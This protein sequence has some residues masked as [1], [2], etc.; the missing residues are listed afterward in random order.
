L[1]GLLGRL[2]QPMG[3]CRDSRRRI[4]RMAQRQGLAL[5]KSRRRDPRASDYGRYRLVDATSDELVMPSQNGYDP[6]IDDVENVL[7][8]NWPPSAGGSQSRAPV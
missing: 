3:S 1:F 5:M 2:P 8:G 7:T 6:S 4:V